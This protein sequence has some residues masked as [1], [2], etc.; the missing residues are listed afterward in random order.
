MSETPDAEP[1]SIQVV[2]GV[3][4]EVVVEPLGVPCVRA[5]AGLHLREVVTKAVVHEMVA[6]GPPV[7][8]GSAR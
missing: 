7:G 6:G 1:V 4:V 2:P 3:V 5:A 8:A